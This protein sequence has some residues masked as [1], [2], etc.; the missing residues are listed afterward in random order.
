MPPSS[1]NLRGDNTP[2]SRS[3]KTAD[4]DRATGDEGGSGN[5]A[6]TGVGAG[7]RGDSGVV[8]QK[9]IVKVGHGAVT[10]LRRSGSISIFETRKRQSGGS[11]RL[12]A[13][14]DITNSASRGG[15]SELREGKKKGEGGG[16]GGWGAKL[17]LSKLRL[18]VESHAQDLGSQV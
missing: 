11:H 7:S 15:S 4:V 1:D 9:N 2:F 18:S 8:A 12:H 14:N 10:E 6:I 17:P 13:W 16:G 5:G 3:L